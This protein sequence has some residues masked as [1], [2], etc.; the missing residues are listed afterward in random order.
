M[1]AT[2]AS[3]LDGFMCEASVVIQHSVSWIVVMLISAAPYSFV[4]NVCKLFHCLWLSSV[5]PFKEGR[6]LKIQNT[7]W[8][9]GFWDSASSEMNLQQQETSLPK[10]T[11][12]TVEVMFIPFTNPPNQ[13]RNRTSLLWLNRQ[14]TSWLA[15]FKKKPII[16]QFCCPHIYCIGTS[17]CHLCH[18]QVAA[19][20]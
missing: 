12:V 4:P 9:H 18:W 3:E 7:Q 2:C 10:T 11:F 17:L 19:I 15:S 16:L 14:I 13:N 5:Q 6:V 8:E 1:A 20:G